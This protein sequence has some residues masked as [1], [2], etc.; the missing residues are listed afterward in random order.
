MT[1]DE[2][3]FDLEQLVEEATELLAEAAH[4]KGLELTCRVPQG[5]HTAYR[6]DA[7]RL[8]QVLVNLLGNAVKFTSRGEIDVRVVELAGAEPGH[9]KLRFEVQDTGIGIQPASLAA[10]FDS[11]SQADG[12]TTRR[13]GGTGLGLAI[14]KQLVQLMGGQIDVHSTPGVGSTF[15]FA[16][17]LRQEAH[18]NIEHQ[19]ES[20]SGRQVLVVDDNATNREILREQLQACGI[21]VTE[22]ASG[23]DAVARLRSR[24]NTGAAFDFAILDYKMPG[25]NGLDVVRAVRADPVLRDLRVMLLSSMSHVEEDTDWRAQRVDACLTKPV[26]RKDLQSVLSRVLAEPQSETVMIRKLQPPTSGSNAPLDLK[27]LLIEDN[28]VN[29]AVAC[30]MLELLGCEVTVASDGIEGA[31]IFAARQFDVVLMDC[32][33]PKLDGYGATAR[34]RAFEQQAGRVRTPVVALTANALEGDRVKCLQAGMD[35]F[36]TK[37]FTKEQ[38]RQ[39]LGAC[40]AAATANDSRQQSASSRTA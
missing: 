16:V 6:G 5:L 1:L 24:A 8:R 34:I 35:E 32:Q 38:L 2:A 14:S 21:R 26:R 39:V 23:E 12:S 18:T 31:S 28:P 29:Q 17:S 33:M 3:P 36:L 20:L 25:M 30:A 7:L 15:G 19:P 9:K 37:P 22:A 27:L 11:F 4:A 10:I 13:Y 40:M